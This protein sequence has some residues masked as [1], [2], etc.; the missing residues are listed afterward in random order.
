[1]SKRKPPSVATIA[2]GRRVLLSV[3]SLDGPMLQALAKVQ[4]SLQTENS[5]PVSTW[6][7]GVTD[8]LQDDMCIHKSISDMPER[9]VNDGA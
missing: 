1:M 6:G 7:D 3:G 8:R 9:G 4:F 2:A 5:A